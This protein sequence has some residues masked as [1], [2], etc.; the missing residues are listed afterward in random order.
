MIIKARK[1]GKE[2][3]VLECLS[4]RMPLSVD[5]ERQLRQM[6][7]GFSGEVWLDRELAVLDQSVAQVSDFVLAGNQ[8]CQLDT[9]LVSA[10]R[11]YVLDVK[12]WGGRYTVGKEGFEGIT[13][14]PLYQ[15]R[16]ASGLFN[17]MLV[18][19]RIGLPVESRLVFVNPQMTLYGLT[20]EMP[21]VLPQ[22]I[23]D[24][25]KEIEQTAGVL[26][27]WEIRI[28]QRIAGCHSDENPYR[29]QVD[30][31]WD[32]VG[33]GILC[34]DCRQLMVERSHKYLVCDRCGIVEGK[35][36]AMLRTKT[37]LDILFPGCVPEMDRLYRFC[38]GMVSKRGIFKALR[39]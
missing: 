12:N 23:P 1:Q 26:T 33:K 6:Q 36:V 38:G 24:F 17:R 13:N 34:A 10:D 18:R 27:E 19:E 22:Q 9:V 37:E 25:L 32:E 14:D 30:Y 2:Q 28:A 16:R 21:I 11:I 5:L 4:G 20:A 8:V 31:T 39:K 29:L 3:M 15:L 7:T 35:G